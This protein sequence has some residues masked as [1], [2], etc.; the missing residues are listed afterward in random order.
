MVE[1]IDVARIFDSMRSLPR[2][3]R[4]ALLAVTF[5]GMSARE[6]S[7]AAGLPPGTGP[8]KVISTLALMGYDDATKRMK[9]ESLHPGV[10]REQV[11]ANTSFEMLF[12]DPLCVTPEPADL[13]L[14]ILRQ[15]VDPQGFVI[16][17]RGQ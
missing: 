7:E 13:E 17:K 15:E 9:V 14:A 10:T 5:L 12:S 11:I 3:Q 2:E 8:Y 1:N 4:S 16:G 6:Y